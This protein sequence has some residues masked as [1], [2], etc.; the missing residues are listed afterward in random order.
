MASTYLKL[1]RED[2]SF[3]DELKALKQKR[4]PITRY[5][6][7]TDNVRE[8]VQSMMRQE[9]FDLCIAFLESK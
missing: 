8:V 5:D 9:G 4:P 1:L 7:Q 6:A 2:P 3:R